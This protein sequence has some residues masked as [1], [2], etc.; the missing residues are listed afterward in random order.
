MYIIS[1]VSVLVTILR[2][3]SLARLVAYNNKDK[4]A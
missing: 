3:N 1:C 4:Y 2:P